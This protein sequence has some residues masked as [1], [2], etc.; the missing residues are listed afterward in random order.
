M[1]DRFDA[2]W[3]LDLTDFKKGAG[4]SLPAKL[5]AEVGSPVCSDMRVQQLIAVRSS[6]ARNL[7]KH[8]LDIFVSSHFCVP[9]PS[10]GVPQHQDTAK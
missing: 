2:R 8:H 3:M 4:S 5:A 10:V 9:Q 1:L 6:F 7:F